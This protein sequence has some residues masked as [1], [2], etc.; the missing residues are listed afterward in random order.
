MNLLRE[1]IRELLTEDPM[2]FVHALAAATDEFGKPGEEFFGGDPGKSGGKAI[3]RAF[4]ANADYQFLNSLDTVH[5]GDAYM[6]SDLFGKSKDELSTTMSLPSE[7][8]RD[9]GGG[10]MGLW[11]K[12]RIT[13]AANNMDELYSGHYNEYGVGGAFGGDEAEVAHR[14]KSSGRNKRPTVAKD[15]SRYGKLEKGNEY[16]EKLARNIPYVLDQ[17]TWDPTSDPNEALVDNWKPIGLII[18][19][20]KDDGIGNALRD[21]EYVEG[22]KEDIE[23]FAIGRT[24]QVMLLALKFGIP[25]YD[26]E[27]DLLWSPK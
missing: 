26:E 24:K 13:L 2:G 16:S 25:I 10:D 11:V 17:S 5:W 7:F 8:L 1:Y 15:Y 4:A 3:K 20:W 6:V 21:M 22:T 14:D 9:A 18:P 27:R 19:T 12:G 23:E